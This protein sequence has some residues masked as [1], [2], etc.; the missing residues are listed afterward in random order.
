MSVDGKPVRLQLCDTA[1][2]VS[3][4][5]LLDLS[6]SGRGEVVGVAQSSPAN[7]FMDLKVFPVFDHVIICCHFHCCITHCFACLLKG[8]GHT[9]PLYRGGHRLLLCWLKLQLCLA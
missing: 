6:V 1:G 7:D 2:Q 8:G 5:T 3:G 9:V 4:V